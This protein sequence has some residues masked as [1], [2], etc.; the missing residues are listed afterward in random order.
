MKIFLEASVHELQESIK[1]GKGSGRMAIHRETKDI[2]RESDQLVKTLSY[3]LPVKKSV[4]DQLNE[5]GLENS[6][7]LEPNVHLNPDGHP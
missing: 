3:H 5:I 7:R 1:A 4:Y 6:E 2:Y